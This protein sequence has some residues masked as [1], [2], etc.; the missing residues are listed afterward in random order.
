MRSARSRL[1]N[2]WALAST[3]ALAATLQAAPASAQAPD[4]QAP[5]EDDAQQ[6][7]IV[8][9]RG[10]AVTDVAAVTTLDADAIA[11]TG[12]ATT[13][14]LL[15]AIRGTTQAADGGEPIFLLNAQ[16]VSGYQEIGSLPPEAIEKVEVLPEQAAL[17]FGFPPTRRVVNFITRRRFQQ[18][19]LR[20]IAGT[21]IRW[22][23]ATQ[24]ANLGM[25]RL[26]EGRRMTLG[27]EVRRT[28]PL[29]QSDRDLLPDPEVPFD[30][31]GN[32]TGVSQGEIDPALSAAAGQIVTIAP[33]P[34]A[35]GD[36]GTLGGFAAG[37][38]TPRLFDAGPYR[39]LAPGTDAFKADAVVADRIG[40]TLAGS[41]TL[42]AEHSRDRSLNGPASARLLVPAANPH[43][44]FTGPVILNRFLTEADPLDQRRTMTNL[45][46][47]LAVRGAVSGL[48]WD[49]TG[50]LSHRRVA[51][52]NEAGIDPAA[53]NAAIA[54]GAD[55]FAPFDAS[56]LTDRL[57]HRTRLRTHN[58]GAK[59]VVTNAPVRLP[60]GR[61]N[62]IG[63]V[64]ADHAAAASSSRGPNP[65][66][67]ELG[68]TRVGAGLALD[69][70]LTSRRDDVLGFVGD[71]SVNGSANVRRVGGFGTLNDS[72]FGV[73]WAPFDG[74]QLLGTLRRSAAAP[75]MAQQL[76]PVASAANVPVYDY[77]NGRTELVTLISG[78][79]P[80]LLA[81][82]RLVRSLSLN[83]KPF[84]KKELR[85]AANYEI[86]TIR[87]QVATVQSVTPQTQ[88]ILPDLFVRDASGRLVS[89]A[90]RP[91]NLAFERQRTLTF[92]LTANGKI[93]KL[94]PPPP[95]GAPRTAPPP[96]LNYYGGIGPT[97]RL[98][99]RLQLRPG[100]PALDLLAG[101]TIRGW[102]MPRVQGWAYAGA[103][104]MGSGATLNLWYQTANRI[105]TGDP[106]DDLHF[107]SVLKVNFSLYLG[108]GGLLKEEKWARRLRLG[109]DVANA[110]DTRQRVTDRSGATPARFQPHFLD[111]QGGTATLS[112]RKLF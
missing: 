93:G 88:A 110:L 86:T 48:R 2:T 102:A 111:P 16:R 99:D 38:N 84:A 15:Q 64:E 12:A 50:N 33:V 35:P 9:E 1:P 43:S 82:R 62:V 18:N 98:E 22:G 51:G 81:E 39:T 78:G 105:R 42:S 54:A 52:L 95:P 77:V 103:N 14:E 90:Y 83:V 76:T 97:I 67:L 87:D 66:E 101:D 11:A 47:G 80:D 41:V 13:G 94:P 100:T 65:S 58:A 59:T 40:E 34:E 108:L 89:V 92:T 68:R 70:P 37:A 23:S 5:A 60:A 31:I 107:S 112:L 30:A 75:D 106:A 8:G 79:N 74:V 63:T 10:S 20:A 104:Y 24:Q 21:T 28:D 19:E 85:L 109:L 4:P 57:I 17:K 91:T 61:V 27:L 55:P 36:R 56:L 46:A 71:V 29:Y 3:A 26:S 7:V 25:T 72:T 96:I 44:P 49:F 73:S 69:V 53:A 45:Q 6:I 32:I